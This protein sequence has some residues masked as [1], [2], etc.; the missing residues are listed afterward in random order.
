MELDFKHPNI[1]KEQIAK[2]VD[3]INIF[4]KHGEIS[5]VLFNLTNMDADFLTKSIFDKNPNP[6]LDCY[7]KYIETN[8]SPTM[9]KDDAIAFENIM[10]FI[11][12]K[13]FSSK[14]SAI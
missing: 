14:R 4:T 8:I 11:L 10:F 1:L 13:L 12:A 2:R 3:M 6:I 7:C 9:V 5:H